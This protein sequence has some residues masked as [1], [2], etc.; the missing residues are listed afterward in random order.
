MSLLGGDRDEP[1]D[2]GANGNELGRAV[3]EAEA[4][5]ADGSAHCYPATFML[6]HGAWHGAWC[7]QFVA[8]PLRAAGHHVIAVTLTGMGDRSDEIDPGVALDTHI[9][10]VLTILLSQRE[11]VVLVGHSYGG[12]VITGAAHQAP[13]RVA[14]LI[15]LDAMVPQNGQSVFDLLRPKY[16]EDFERGAKIHG[17]GW[18][19]PPASAQLLGITEACQ[20]RWLTALLTHQP[21]RT[22][23]QPISICESQDSALPATYIHCTVGPLVSEL[24]RFAARFRGLGKSVFYQL[25]TGHDAMLTQPAVLAAVLL[26]ASSV[27]ALTRN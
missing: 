24:E 25:A 20:A 6:V 11:P 12:M 9:R 17:G 26:E 14:H 4:R 18:R 23:T 2:I 7:W 21:L 1:G 10:D 27:L 22:F 5:R 8:P 15:Y 19:I 16:R 3:F 13:D